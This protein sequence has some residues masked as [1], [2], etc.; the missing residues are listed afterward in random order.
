MGGNSSNEFIE[1]EVVASGQISVERGLFDAESGL[2]R[3]DLATPAAEEF[4]LSHR[5]RDQGIRILLATGIIALHDHP[6]AI[7]SLCK[8]QYKHAV[9]CAEAAVKYPAT[10]QI[11]S[12]DN[13]I[14]V[15]GPIPSGSS[16]GKVFKSAVRSALAI[17][18]LRAALMNGVK[19]IERIVPQDALLLPLYR[20]TM[21]LYFIA[22]VRDG[23]RRYS[24]S[25]NIE[26]G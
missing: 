26:A 16:A 14:T 17:K 20:I 7:E 1:N 24:S 13:V 11:K 19:L 12:L 9:G 8:Q 25:S 6:L 15:N 21:S 18:P 10:R 23:L 22:G 2:Y 5:L 3:D 4:E